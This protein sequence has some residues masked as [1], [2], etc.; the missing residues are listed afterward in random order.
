M[1][2]SLSIK[3]THSQFIA[4]LSDKG[5]NVNIQLL[6][7]HNNKLKEFGEYLY[8]HIILFCT[9]ENESKFLSTQQ[10]IEFYDSG[11]NLLVAGDIDTSKVFR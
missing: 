6:S 9:S 3:N 11:R 8:D 1:V 5:F 10:L 2:D 7:S 4:D